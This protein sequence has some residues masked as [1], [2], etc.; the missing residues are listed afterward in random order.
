MDTKFIRLKMKI[1]LIITLFIIGLGLKPQAQIL[2]KLK[3][4]AQEKGL[5]TREVSYDTT[6]IEIT[7]STNVAEAE[8][9]INSAKDFFNSDVIMTMFDENGNYIQTQFFDAI[10]LPCV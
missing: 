10:H 6:A 9:S 8:L 1:K 3:E 2:D 7:K 4:R 5:E